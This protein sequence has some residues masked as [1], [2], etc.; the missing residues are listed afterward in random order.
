MYLWYEFD[1]HQPFC[2]IVSSLSPF[3]AKYVAAPIL[4][5]W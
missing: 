3:N 4:N 1:D 5:E 2:F